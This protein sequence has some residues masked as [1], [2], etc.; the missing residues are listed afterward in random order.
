M[1]PIPNN[2]PAPADMDLAT[3]LREMARVLHN[4]GG[5][6]H[7]AG[8]SAKLA[9]AAM[10][11]VHLTSGERVQRNDDGSLD[12]IVGAGLTHIEHLGGNRWF[13]AIGF[14]DGTE[15]CLWFNGK[16]TLEEER[17]AVDAPPAPEAA[18]EADHE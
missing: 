3:L 7:G 12:E 17:E 18:K 1:T 11:W 8:Y 2:L 13:L 16:I 14:A 5:E 10:K 4:A 15:H 6:A 9:D